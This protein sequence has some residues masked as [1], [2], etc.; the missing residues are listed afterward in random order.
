MSRPQ[1]TQLLILIVNF[2]NRSVIKGDIGDFH[3]VPSCRS[4]IFF[5]K[6]HVVVVWGVRI[7]RVNTSATQKSAQEKYFRFAAAIFENGRNRLGQSPIGRINRQNML[8]T[9]ETAPEKYIQFAATSVENDRHR[10]GQP[11]TVGIHRETT[12]ATSRTAAE[13]YLRFVAATLENIEIY[14][15]PRESDSSEKSRH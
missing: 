13:K 7:N 15:S 1:N 12:S 4:L 3:N 8:A 14:C 9:P 6:I 2:L 5:R 10:R 11:Q